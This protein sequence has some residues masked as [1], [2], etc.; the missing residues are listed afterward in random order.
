V[1]VLDGSGW[2]SDAEAPVST[3]GGPN[4]LIV[5]GDRVGGGV[6]LGGTVRLG[7]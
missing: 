6:R 4:G 1:L 5:A 3:T 2:V 7:S